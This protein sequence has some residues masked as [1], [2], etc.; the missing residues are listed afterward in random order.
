VPKNSCKFVSIYLRDIPHL[1]VSVLIFTVPPRFASSEISARTV[2][3]AAAP[4][5]ETSGNV[6]REGLLVA[7]AGFPVRLAASDHQGPFV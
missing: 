4:A 5:A 7:V 1:F 3:S 2:A 6:V